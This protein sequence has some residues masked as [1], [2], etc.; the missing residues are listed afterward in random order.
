MSQQK[1]IATFTVTHRNIIF[2]FVSVVTV[3][4]GGNMWIN[5]ATQSDISVIKSEIM[6]INST[7]SVNKQVIKENNQKF[8]AAN[9]ARIS[10][11]AKLSAN[12]KQLA[13]HCGVTLFYDIARNIKYNN[14]Q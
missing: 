13:E 7:V 9:D 1:P 11:I 3:L 4:S 6:N 8:E 10:E 2:I 14:A 12:Q 5:V